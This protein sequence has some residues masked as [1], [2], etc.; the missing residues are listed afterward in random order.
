MRSVWQDIATVEG[1]LPTLQEVSNELAAAPGNCTFSVACS[2]C[3]VEI[4]LA[5]VVKE[6]T[7]IA[8][9]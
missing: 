3:S 7:S 4:S 6:L 5:G 8:K 2:V 9:P 1:T